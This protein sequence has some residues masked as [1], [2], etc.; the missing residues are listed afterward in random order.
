[1]WLKKCALNY[2]WCNTEWGLY[3]NLHHLFFW[4]GEKKDQVT[5]VSMFA[6]WT[7]SPFLSTPLISF[8]PPIP[9][10]S[11]VSPYIDVVTVCFSLSLSEAWL[12]I[13]IQLTTHYQQ[14]YPIACY[15]AHIF[16]TG[17][18]RKSFTYK[19]LDTSSKQSD[20]W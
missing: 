13:L 20:Q 19:H 7:W 15:Q 10:I 11:F 1:M 14:I 17:L 4:E 3:F 18:D 12:S 9:F 8:F 2:F 6:L 5:F 16:W